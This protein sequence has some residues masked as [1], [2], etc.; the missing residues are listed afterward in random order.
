MLTA[1]T[2]V[3]FK[4]TAGVLA[5]TPVR[6]AVAAA[7]DP[8]SIIKNLDYP[9]RPVREPLLIGQLGYDPQYAQHTNDPATARS[10]LDGAG[11]L[12]GQDGYRYK[13]GKK[14][15]F[16]LSIADTGEYRRVASQLQAQLKTVGIDMQVTKYAA[17]DFQSIV[18]SH[19]YDAV[20]YGI[21]IGI[22]PDVFA[23]WD[24]SQADIRSSNRLNLSEYKSSVVDD[25]LDGGRTRSDPALR[26]IKYRGFLQQWQ[27]DAPALGLYQPRSLYITNGKVYGLTEHSS[28]ESTDRLFYANEWMIRTARVTNTR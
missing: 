7:A 10:L 11:W 27:Q 12:V 25:A 1:A 6:K 4:T 15:Q 16:T 3:F 17:I 28:N 13:D 24:S 22:D 5:E 21:S 19:S 2:M 9:T 20:L 26:V 8:A 14:L 18:S 23:Y